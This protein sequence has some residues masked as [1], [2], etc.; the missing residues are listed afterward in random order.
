MTTP[1]TTTSPTN[2]LTN[3]ANAFTPATGKM[4][5]QQETLSTWAGPYVTVERRALAALLL[6]LVF[7]EKAVESTGLVASPLLQSEPPVGP[8]VVI[9]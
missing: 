2:A 5:G 9:D 1:A 4:T 6:H 3:V 8:R 7:P